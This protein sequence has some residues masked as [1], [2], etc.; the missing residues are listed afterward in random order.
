[1]RA[2]RMSIPHRIRFAG[3]LLACL[4]ALLCSLG[5][6]SIAHAQ[7]ASASY[8]D[9]AGEERQVEATVIDAASTAWQSGWYV[10]QG[11][12]TIPER[13]TVAGDVHVIL[14]DG[15]TLT[16][17]DGLNVA[18]GNSLSVYGQQEGTGSLS[19]EIRD[20]YNDES[21]P[22]GANAGHAGFG[23]ITI[24]GGIVDATSL[25]A[26]VSIGSA[27]DPDTMDKLG[28]ITVNGGTVNAGNIGGS[29][30]ISSDLYGPVIINSD[31][32]IV[33]ASRIRT[34]TPS[35]SWH[36]LIILDNQARTYATD[37]ITT[38]VA[39]EWDETLAVPADTTLTLKG[40]LSAQTISVDGTLRL[41]GGA[42]LGG[43]ATIN[44]T[45]ENSAGSTVEASGDVRV[46]PAATL[47]NEGTMQAD[48]RITLEDGSSL[49][50][51]GTLETK[52]RLTL[53]EGAQLANNADAKAT[54]SGDLYLWGAVTNSGTVELN[55]MS[56][57]FED[58][59]IQN[60]D[61]ASFA[62]SGSAFVFGSLKSE[63]T[64]HNNGHLYHL[65]GAKVID[66]TVSGVAPEAL[67]CIDVDGEVQT[68]PTDVQVVTSADETWQDGGWYLAVGDVT[69]EGR[70]A[71]GSDVT[72]VMLE[73][74]SLTVNGG[75]AVD[76]G[77]S[78]TVLGQNER[79][80]SLVLGVTENN[81]SGRI[82][83]NLAGIGGGGD[84]VL[85]SAGSIT[86]R[87]GSGTGG[88]GIGT[89]DS[90]GTVSIVRGT[91]SALGGTSS[92][93]GSPAIGG[94]TVRI[95]GGTVDATGGQGAAAIGTGSGQ[96]FNAHIVISG[97]TVTANGQ[98]V[99]VGIGAGG[100]SK[101]NGENG[102]VEITGGTVTAKGGTSS[103]GI[104]GSGQ[105]G[106]GVPVHISGGFVTAEGGYA[107]TPSDGRGAGIGAGRQGSDQGSFI[108]DGN[109]VIIA[110]SIGDRSSQQ[111]WNGIFFIGGYWGD[112]HGD[113]ELTEDV[114]IPAGYILSAA[115]GS[116]VTVAKDAT[117]T[118]EGSISFYP[119]S[120][121]T[122]E[123][124]VV[125]RGS[126]SFYTGCDA[127]NSGTIEGS[128]RK[129][130]QDAATDVRVVDATAD[131]LT[132]EAQVDAARGEVR[133][134]LVEGGA[135]APAAS[136]DIWQESPSFDGLAAGTSYTAYVLFS[137]NDLYDPA[138]SQG[139]LAWTAR[140]V[141]AQGEGYALDYAGE[142]IAALD[143]YELSLDGDAWSAGPFD[144]EPGQEVFVRAA[145]L[146]GGAPESE[147]FSLM[148]PERPEAPQLAAEA[149][150]SEGA[151]NGAIRIEA[152]LAEAT[153]EISADGGSTWEEAALDEEGRITGLAGGVYLVRVKATT[154]ENGVDGFFVGEASRAS[155]TTLE[156]VSGDAGP[157]SGGDS[158]ADGHLASTGDESMKGVLFALAVGLLVIVSGVC[159]RRTGR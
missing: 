71:A 41:E 139:V 11:S 4:V 115:G 79:A 106:N 59:S 15:A 54:V 157:S 146:D 82:E 80:G 134:A 20:P 113:V 76:E 121:F 27:A 91:V 150:S 103:A 86:A 127:R 16:A 74:S 84:I 60:A 97:G 34:S 52:N 148:L 125:N 35:D 153:Y 2:S 1:M 119:G 155:V 118:N 87:S 154:A 90:R 133:F 78:L 100:S 152:P 138:V 73:G 61:G 81:V 22:L 23:D 30:R 141:P 123:G 142:T 158:E 93:S 6:P 47:E 12:V 112:V 65:E 137:G 26:G 45:L 124:T 83:P 98:Y 3:C 159:L 9:A 89:T 72:L 25:A 110:T 42:T 40:S 36:G 48:G 7:T 68:I 70:V 111:D 10:A 53:Y 128:Y 102:L 101:G 122:N 129:A 32:A 18:S 37:T 109:A 116:S 33:R 94:E 21:S 5:A 131:S 136:S 49:E 29:A 44:G 19:V 58:G 43:S 117:L 145:A 56:L 143:G 130:G 13:V 99:G 108:A 75:I 95:S 149:E 135:A 31:E 38:D 51:S 14:V 151:T 104:G 77:S 8:I 62:N 66:G 46:A 92:N 39:L 96:T 114:T 88:A 105:F 57:V 126:L 147:R 24:N 63:E 69:I 156:A 140:A 120:A 132:V 28:T 17:Q 107:R 64:I 55:A 144:I 50:N 67:T 85:A